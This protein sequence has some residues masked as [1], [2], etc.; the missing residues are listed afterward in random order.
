MGNTSE[1]NKEL[2]K[3]EKTSEGQTIKEIGILN[4][5]Y[6]LLEIMI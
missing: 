4:K 3:F 6:M 2:E 1:T 5:I